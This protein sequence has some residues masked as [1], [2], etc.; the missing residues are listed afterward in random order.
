M[1]P[2]RRPSSVAGLRRAVSAPPPP[3]TSST[4]SSPPEKAEKKVRVTLNIPPDL[5]RQ[6]TRWADEVAEGIGQPRGD[7]QKTLR[8]L[9]RVASG[10]AANTTLRVQASLRE[11]PD[12]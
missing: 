11:H 1:S 6:F 3:T 8:A 2:T 10:G 4:Y 12:G 5:Y 9:I 7:V